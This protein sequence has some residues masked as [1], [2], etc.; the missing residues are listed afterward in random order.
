M[1]G[2]GESS[3]RHEY[4]PGLSG[5]VDLPVGIPLVWNDGLSIAGDAAT[6]VRKR[7]NVAQVFMVL[8]TSPAS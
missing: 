3:G 8:H 5:P 7:M 2:C 1:G 6:K 4:S